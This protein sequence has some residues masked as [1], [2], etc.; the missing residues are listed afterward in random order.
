MKPLNLNEWL[1]LLANVGVIAGI[2]FLAIEIR[3]N[4]NMM[5]AQT[6]ESVSQN[7]M[8][9]LSSVAGNLELSEI[10]V[11]GSLG[12]LENGW[13]AEWIAFQSQAEVGFRS[14]E[15]EFYQYEQGLFQD[16][17]FFPHQETWR[18]LLATPGFRQ[19]WEGARE[20]YSVRFRQVIDQMIADIENAKA[21]RCVI[22][23]K[24]KDRTVCI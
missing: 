4:T 13:N 16:D 6:R 2:V 24:N 10:M 21:H 5:Q 18:N 7:I 1:S 9:A 14:W 3:Q 20:G 15:N 19:V 12:E 17:E 23:L 22:G 11:K 8:L